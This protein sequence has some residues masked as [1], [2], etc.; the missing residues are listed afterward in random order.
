MWMQYFAFDIMGEVGFG[1]SF[2][3]AAT[4]RSHFETEFLRHGM[5]MLA[6]VTPIPW[7]YHLALAIPAVPGFTKDWLD[8]LAWSVDQAKLKLQVLLPAN[9]MI[10]YSPLP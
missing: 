2:H 9:V 4:G 10:N 5:S 1:E 3:Q 8:L 7:L 6:W